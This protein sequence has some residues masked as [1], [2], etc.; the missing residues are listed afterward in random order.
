M[1][2]SSDALVNEAD[3]R[4]AA[5]ALAT[6]YEQEKVTLSVTLAELGRQ[7]SDSLNREPV[8]TSAGVIEPAIRIERTTCGLRIP[9]EQQPLEPG[10]PTKEPTS[11]D[12]STE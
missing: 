12:P 7:R 10:D 6:Y 11:G 3:P 1:R 2:I 4:M 5:K 9:E 8:E